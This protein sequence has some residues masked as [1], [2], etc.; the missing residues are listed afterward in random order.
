VK[1]EYPQSMQ[2]KRFGNSQTP[3]SFSFLI[4]EKWR[5]ICEENSL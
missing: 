5:M 4:P 2:T 3:G 1:W